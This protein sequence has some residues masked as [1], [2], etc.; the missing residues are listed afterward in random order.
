MADNSNN[1]NNNDAALRGSLIALAAVMAAVG[2]WTHSMRK[3][4]VTY[5]VGM[6]GIA[7]IL[8][9]D[10]DYFDRDYSRWFYPVTEQEKLALSRRSGLREQDLPS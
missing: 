6:L 9:P 10:W 7:G 3:V 1:N 8:L 4:G 2:I 5:M